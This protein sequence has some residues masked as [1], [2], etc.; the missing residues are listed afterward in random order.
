MSRRTSWLIAASAC[1]L[2]A[3]VLMW[4]T[5]RGATT[6]SELGER[7]QRTEEKLRNVQERVDRANDRPGT[8]REIVTRVEVPVERE[9]TTRANA[10]RDE[11]DPIE[12]ANEQLDTE[13]R[14]PAWAADTERSLQS[15]YR[16]PT[17]SGSRLGE[18]RCSSSVCRLSFT[19]ADDDAV[20]K[21]RENV[22]LTNPLPDSS[23]LV[24]MEQNP[25]GEYESTVFVKRPEKVEN[26]G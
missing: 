24:H 10:P 5:Q 1:V 25:H 7:L 8:T 13:G 19:H 17:L 2:A 26:G 9:P 21:F 23:V 6:D 20:A 14:D 22:S 16:S 15:A 4:R 18:V 3:S 12:R 11:R